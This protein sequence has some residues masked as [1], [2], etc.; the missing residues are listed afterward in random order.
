MIYKDP[1][2]IEIGRRLQKYDRIYV[3]GQISYIT[4]EYPDGVSYSNGFIQ[5]KN[6]VVFKKFS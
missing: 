6:L 2:L 5:P 1:H 4:K 3:N